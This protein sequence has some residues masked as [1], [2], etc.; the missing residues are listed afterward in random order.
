[1]AI[2]AAELLVKL[3]V[4]TGPGNSTAGTPGGSLGGFISTTVVD[5]A[6]LLH[7]LF[8]RISGDENAA[9]TVDYR[10]VLLHNSNASLTLQAPV[11]YIS[12]EV[13][14][15]ASVAISVDATATSALGST[16]AQMKS[17]ANETTAPATQTFSAPTTKATGLALSD[18]PA[19]NV[20]G[21]WIQRTAANSA[22]VDSDG[23]TL[24]IAGDTAA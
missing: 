1:M 14:G 6:T 3:S 19:G 22:A 16:T 15:G 24:A 17:V 10:G 2:T 23:F 8:D 13:A 20:K 5:Q 12:A 18:V 21:V 11:A 4:G 9:S 7:N